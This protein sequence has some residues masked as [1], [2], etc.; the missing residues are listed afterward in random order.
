MRDFEAIP[1]AP[2]F[3]KLRALKD[4][5]VTITRIEPGERVNVA[6]YE[7]S[8]EAEITPKLDEL[9]RGLFLATSWFRSSG[10]K[11]QM[12]QDYYLIFGPFSLLALSGPLG[13][14]FEGAMKGD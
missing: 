1:I 12:R 13:A 14:A 2:A 3:W 4:K 10:E 11:I 9:G 6:T 7:V 8:G 5:P